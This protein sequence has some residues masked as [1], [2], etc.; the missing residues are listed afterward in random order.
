MGGID[1]IRVRPPIL[2][3]QSFVDRGKTSVT[4]LPA[5]IIN[6]LFIVSSRRASVKITKKHPET[7]K[8]IDKLNRP[9]YNT[10][11]LQAGATLA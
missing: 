7:Q 5:P 2:V 4:Q 9:Y 6:L 10:F 3:Y 8:T 1:K 11:C